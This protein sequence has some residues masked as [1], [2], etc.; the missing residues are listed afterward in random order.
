LPLHCA[1]Q[2]KSQRQVWGHQLDVTGMRLGS[3]E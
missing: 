3:G 2:L 1:M